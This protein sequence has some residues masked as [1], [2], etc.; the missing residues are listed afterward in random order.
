MRPYNKVL[1]NNLGRFLDVRP[2]T[3][4]K[5]LFR[6]RLKALKFFWRTMGETC[7]NNFRKINSINFGG[8]NQSRV[9][10]C[11]LEIMGCRT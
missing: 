8:K 1:Q 3:I 4:P 6:N 11:R 2:Q 10:G 5:R 7:E 9:T